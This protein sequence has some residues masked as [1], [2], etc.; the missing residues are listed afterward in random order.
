MAR[1]EYAKLRSP[2]GECH[3]F[4]AASGTR[5]AGTP[6][7]VEDVLVYPLETTTSAVGVVAYEIPKV[8]V[9]KLA[10]IW[11]AGVKVFWDGTNFT[12]DDSGTTETPVGVCVEAAAATDSEGLIHFVG[13]QLPYGDVDTNPS[14]A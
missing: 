9:N 12:I 7:I 8:L 13:A 3:T 1:V 4:V 6:V 2:I 5:T 11:A 14:T 10:E